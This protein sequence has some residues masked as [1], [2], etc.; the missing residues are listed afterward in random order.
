VKFL[1]AK[2]SAVER[3]LRNRPPRVDTQVFGK[4]G[5]IATRIVEKKI[6]RPGRFLD[7]GEHFGDLITLADITLCSEDLRTKP[8]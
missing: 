7:P 3:N 6:Y 8:A 2:K 1:T 5:E 4:C